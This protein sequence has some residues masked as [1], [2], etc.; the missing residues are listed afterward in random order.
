VRHLLARGAIGLVTTHDLALAKIAEAM[1]GRAANF[2]F[3]DQLDDDKLRF[4]YKLTP[5][6]VQTTNAL[7]LMR[8]IGLDV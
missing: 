4:D 3:A 2:H 5:G 7:K 6:T 1:P 8:S